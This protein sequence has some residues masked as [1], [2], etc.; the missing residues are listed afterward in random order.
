[1]GLSDYYEGFDISN[2]NKR[3]PIFTTIPKDYKDINDKLYPLIEEYRNNHSE[4]LETNVRATWRSDWEVHKH[5]QFNFFVE[6]ILKATSFISA[7]HLNTNIQYDVCNMWLMIYE[8][9]DY[10]IPHDHFPSTMSVVYYVDVENNAAPITFEDELDIHPETG[11]LIIFPSVI[12]H[13]VNKT[14]TK[15]VVVGMNLNAGFW[16]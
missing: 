11:K 9:G 14:N 5:E 4:N 12:Q 6:W 13:K 3:L 10:A 16:D 7:Y 2:V 8:K 15:R 1:M